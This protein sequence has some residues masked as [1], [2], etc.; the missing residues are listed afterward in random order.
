M[1]QISRLRLLH[2]PFLV[3]LLLVL[4]LTPLS[5]AEAF[6]QLGSEFRANTTTTRGQMLPAIAMHTDGSFIITWQSDQLGS[7]NQDIYAQRFGATGNPIDDEFTVNTNVDAFIQQ[8]P[9]IDIDDDGNFVIAWAGSSTG[10]TN[11]IYA[12]IYNAS[13][14]PQGDQILVSTATSSVQFSPNVAVD[15]DGDFVVTWQRAPATFFPYVIYA[16]QFNAVGVAQGVEFRVNTTTTG[17]QLYGRVAMDPVGNFIVAWENAADIYAQRYSP[18]GVP[19]GSE[20]LVSTTAGSQH[21][22]SL[23]SDSNGNFV[24]T[25]S[26]ASSQNARRYNV[27]GVPQ[28]GEFQVSATHSGGWISMN[29]DGEF[30]IV[31]AG[32]GIW[33]RRFNAD[34]SPRGGEFQINTLSGGENPKIAIDLFGNFAV[35]WMRTDTTQYDVYAVRFGEPPVLSVSLTSLSFVADEGDGLTPAQIVTISNTAVP[36]SALNFY[37]DTLPDWLIC[38]DPSTNTLV[39]GASTTISCQGDPGVLTPQ[40]YNGSFEIVS[41]TSG[42]IGSPQT[43]NV[44]FTISSGPVVTVITE[45]EFYTAF[46]QQRANYP[47]IAAGIADFVPDGIDMTLSLATGEVGIINFLV[48]E[49]NSFLVIRIYWVETLEGNPVSQNYL[50]VINRDLAPLITATLDSILVARFGSTQNVEGV[51]VDDNTMTLSVIGS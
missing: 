50:N 4:M 23:A 19:Q 20:F 48:I 35:T 28:G 38:T 2:L 40:T 1:S 46:E 41:F 15:D 3:S 30:V 7:G 26:Q 14:V 49:S 21:N 31:T 42:V 37:V 17:N 18:A 16:R 44:S 22:P 39:S 29:S 6:G 47:A 36:G 9:A 11:E 8:S 13:G 27:G 33:A 45:N 12:R 43:V 32:S 24:I 25:W 34:T 10:E 5:R 51:F